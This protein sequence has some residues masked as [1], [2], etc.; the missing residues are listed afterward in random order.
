[1]L[2]HS[3]PSA[4]LPEIP[5]NALTTIFPTFIVVKYSVTAEQCGPCYRNKHHFLSPTPATPATHK[6][7]FAGMRLIM[8]KLFVLFKNTK[9]PKVAG[10]LY[11][12]ILII[13]PSFSGYYI[14]F[15]ASYGN[16]PDNFL[17]S[18][19]SLKRCLTMEHRCAH[20]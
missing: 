16:S 1:M 13:K 15:I 8:Y 2:S 11:H 12:E 17:S 3:N 6:N 7:T 18:Q 9:T 4:T 19:I 14:L 5:L 20:A 10:L